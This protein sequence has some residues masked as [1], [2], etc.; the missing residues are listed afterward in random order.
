MQFQLLDSLSLPGDP[1]K[2]NEDSFSHA[3]G[4]AC[5]FDGTTVLG[6]NLMP[7]PSD[8]QWIAQFGARR[9]RAHAESSS[10]SPRHALRAAAA[11]T[12]KSFAALRR[13]APSETYETPFSSLM[14]LF[15]RDEKLEALW[16]G[17]CAA[18]I[19]SANGAVSVV[20]E[21]LKVRA[22]ERDR[23]STM[24]ESEGMAATSVREKFLPALRAS[25]NRVNKKGS[26]WLFSPDAKCARHAAEAKLTVDPASH[27]L[28]ASDGF[29]ALV[30]DYGRYSADELMSA[31]IEHGL[32]ALGKEL[33]AIEA[34][35]PTGLAFP[36]FKSSDDATAL[37]LS[38]TT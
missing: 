6:E 30:S 17:D 3:A 7:G 27:I 25:R 16:F 2:P 34:G 37:L 18:L 29:F 19:K 9:L 24:G 8:A 4:F 12:E 11:D 10:V 13:R 38:L 35:D 1:T 20:G 14:A 21:T 32:A 15:I 26:D 36:R 22:H 31:T 23:A 28:L 33:R 5:V